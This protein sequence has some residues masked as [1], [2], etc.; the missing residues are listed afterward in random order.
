MLSTGSRPQC[1]AVTLRSKLQVRIILRPTRTLAGNCPAV[2]KIETYRRPDVPVIAR[3]ALGNHQLNSFSCTVSICGVRPNPHTL[4]S[5]KPHQDTIDAIQG[6][7]VQDSWD[8][9]LVVMLQALQNLK[10]RLRIKFLTPVPL[11]PPL[12][13]R[14]G[15]AFTT[16]LADETC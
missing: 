6:E 10:N 3:T 12:P 8:V 9:A 1:S 7:F 15:T 5:S 11:P 4:G 16:M 14:P 13:T 2:S